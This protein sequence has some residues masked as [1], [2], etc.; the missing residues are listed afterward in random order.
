MRNC[1]NSIPE[2]MRDFNPAPRAA[3]VKSDSLVKGFTDK[4]IFPL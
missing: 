4:K 3:A 1:R 2:E